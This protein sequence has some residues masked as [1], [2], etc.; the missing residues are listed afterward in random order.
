MLNSNFSEIEMA[1]FLITILVEKKPI[2]TQSKLYFRS[3]D[4]GLQRSRLAFFFLNI[5]LGKCT[6]IVYLHK[7]LSRALWCLSAFSNLTHLSC[8]H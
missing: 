8:I 7:N 3:E 2:E 5:Y 6:P 4:D 1:G